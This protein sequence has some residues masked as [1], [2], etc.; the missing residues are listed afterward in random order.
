MPRPHRRP[1]RSG[2]LRGIALDDFGTGFG[3]FTYLHRLPVSEPKIDR[4][5]VSQVRDS[6][7]NQRVVR[8][9]IAIARNFGMRTVAEGIED[10]GTLGTLVEMGVD[11]GQGFLL[12]R[13]AR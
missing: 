10:R 13:P 7:T 1:L 12:G 6:A 11:L 8:T 9:M 4:E 3:T 2:H 5:F